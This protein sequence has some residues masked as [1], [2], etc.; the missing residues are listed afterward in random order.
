MLFDWAITD[1]DQESWELRVKVIVAK[2]NPGDLFKTDQVIVSSIVLK[3]TDRS[4]Q[5]I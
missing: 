4:N 5:Q 1:L 2:L 3:N